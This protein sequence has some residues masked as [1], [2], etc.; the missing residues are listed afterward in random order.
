MKN[1]MKCQT[2][3]MA[4][5]RKATTPRLVRESDLPGSPPAAAVAWI[6]RRGRAVLLPL[7]GKSSHCSRDIPHTLAPSRLRALW[8]FYTTHA[9]TA[10]SS[11][12]RG[13]PLPNVLIHGAP[14]SG[15]SVLARRLVGMCGLNTVVVAG[16]DV[17]SLG[18][19]ASS[20]LS[21]LMRWAGGGG[22]GSGSSRGK[23]VAVVMDEAEA[24][25]GDRRKKGMSENAR[26]A[27]NAVLLSTGELRAGFLMVLTTSRPQDLDEAILDRVDEVVHLPTPGLPER[28]RLIRQYFC[29]Y[30]HHDP[31]TDFLRAPAALGSA[32]ARAVRAPAVEA[33]SPVGGRESS[34]AGGWHFRT[35]STSS[36]SSTSSTIDSNSNT[37]SRD[38]DNVDRDLD[39]NGERQEFVASRKEG[40]RPTAMAK[41]AT[42]AA[43]AAVAAA[44]ASTTQQHQPES[45]LPADTTD[46]EKENPRTGGGGGGV[47]LSDGFR[48][49]AAGLMAMLAVRSEGFYGRD[50]AHFF[51]AVQAAVFGSED[52]ELTE[53]L[54]ASTER[55]KLKEFSEKLILTATAAANAASK[56]TSPPKSSPSL[57]QQRRVCTTTT[58]LGDATKLGIGR[59]VSNAG[60]HEGRSAS[61][62]PARANWVR[63]PAADAGA[64]AAPCSSSFGDG[65]NCGGV[66]NS[67]V[68]SDSWPQGHSTG[69][70]NNSDAAAATGGLAPGR[71][72]FEA[73]AS[74]SEDKAEEEEKMELVVTSV[75]ALRP[76]CDPEI[77]H[78]ERFTD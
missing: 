64:N 17:G 60:T 72:V 2:S 66:A 24:A 51:S 73:A 42:A 6:A 45:H 61:P 74:L 13:A 33:I 46:D 62:P 30:L 28:A 31:P 29:S 40:G 9:V 68:S 52:Y 12:R 23:G 78:P 47:R 3:A 8:C 43:A 19:N 38:I 56:G 34:A 71:A 27:L 10:S 44:A 48:A 41:V 57:L 67:K 59:N 1:I 70:G 35:N 58:T 55:Q 15:K 7:L 20:E 77:T 5:Q 21:G 75:G 39:A 22:G 54:W 76:P 4:I 14:G 49:K 69:K 11:Y 53:A 50:M 36:T 26:S 65:S 16:G 25:L 63:A 32:A 18:R 37:G